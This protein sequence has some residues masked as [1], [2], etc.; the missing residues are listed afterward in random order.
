MNQVTA[1]GLC[2]LYVIPHGNPERLGDPMV[3]VL[4][5]KEVGWEGKGWGRRTGVR[6]ERT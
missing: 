5:C 1:P 6:T 4:I 2:E 3:L